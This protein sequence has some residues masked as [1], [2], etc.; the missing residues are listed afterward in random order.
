MHMCIYCNLMT[1]APALMVP[2]VF[3]YLDEE[4]VGE[5]S[6]EEVAAFHRDMHGCDRQNAE[7]ARML[8]GMKCRSRNFKRVLE[9]L[10]IQ[11]QRD[12]SL[13]WDFD[14][15]DLENSGVIVLPEAREVWGLNAIDPRQTEQPFEKIVEKSSISTSSVSASVEERSGLQWETFKKNLLQPPSVEAYTA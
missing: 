1:D 14:I 2:E 15:M 6:F 8:E 12:T 5:L 11:C 4:G 9:M 7:I 3:D 10:H 13:T